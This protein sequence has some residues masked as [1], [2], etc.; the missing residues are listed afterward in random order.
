MDDP[1]VIMGEPGAATKDG[2]PYDLDV[3]IMGWPC[4]CAT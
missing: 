4:P 1:V 3:V 2:E